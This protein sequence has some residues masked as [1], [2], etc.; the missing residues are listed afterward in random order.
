MSQARRFVD[1]AKP[2]TSTISMLQSATV[3]PPKSCYSLWVN[4]STHEEYEECLSWC[5]SSY[6][7]RSDDGALAAR[8]HLFAQFAA[9][10]WKLQ[11]WLIREQLCEGQTRKLV[12]CHTSTLYHFAQK[13][14]STSSPNAKESVLTPLLARLSEASANSRFNTSAFGLH[15]AG[16]DRSES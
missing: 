13:E 14:F 6:G 10:I 4:D 9:L 12:P 8:A 3:S 7:N 2:P 15:V 5:N 16:S 1:G 11:I